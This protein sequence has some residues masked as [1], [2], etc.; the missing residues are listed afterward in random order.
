[1]TDTRALLH[2]AVDRA[3]DFIDSLGTRGVQ[4]TATY[5][6]MVAAFAEPVPTHGR[7]A[8]AVLKDLATM[9][10]PGLVAMGSGRYFGFVVGGSVPA[11][12]AADV[13]VTGWDQNTGLTFGTPATAAIE[14]VAGDWIKELLHLPASATVGFVTGGLMANFTGLAAARHRVFADVGWDVEA[15][16][17]H[18]APA[19]RL[20]CGRERHATIDMAARYLGLGSRH[21]I[22]VATDEQS[23]IVLDD[24][25]AA[26]EGGAGPTVVCL[27]AGNVNTGA[28]DPLAEA[29][30]LAHEYGAWVHVDGAFGLWAAAAPNRQYLTAGLE[31]ADSWATDG[32][33]WL[34]VPYDCG[35]AIVAH[36]QAHRQPLGAKAAYLIRE[37]GDP[38]PF[39]LVPEFSRRARGVPVYAALASLGR[40][41]VAD[42]IERCCTYAADFG[43]SLN[44]VDGISVLNDVVLNQVLV[45]FSDS[46]EVTNEV[47]A[48]VLAEGVAY[49]TPTVWKGHAAL[50]ISVTNWRTNASDVAAAVDSIVRC[51]SSA[52]RNRS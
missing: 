9:A 12:A 21:M 15:D 3:G 2:D 46:D 24:L 14:H 39:E 38:D 8:Q 7:D 4:A 52:L 20:I 51:Y 36:E 49:M 27:A 19:L 30:D 22:E 5:P 35:I 13:L 33:K 6:E 32:H 26:L 10:E 29:I 44:A 50:R 18:G 45:R 28:F 43:T 47:A 11:A 23:R 16:G 34:N 42:L 41:G 48:A 17:L 37:G 25:R 40:D 31:R 1:M